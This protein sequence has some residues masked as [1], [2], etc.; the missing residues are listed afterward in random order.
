M[1]PVSWD[2]YRVLSHH[3]P[4]SSKKSLS[5]LRIRSAV[6]ADSGVFLCKGVNGFGT[7]N[8]HIQL[9]VRGEVFLVLKSGKFRCAFTRE[10]MLWP[11]EGGIVS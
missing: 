4:P 7:A 6:V 10:I 2:R 1:I 9:V 5:T 8:A 11:A 3:H